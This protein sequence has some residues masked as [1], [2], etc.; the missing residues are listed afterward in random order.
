MP[1]R[2][3]RAGVWRISGDCRRPSPCDRHHRGS[4][5]HGRTRFCRK[6]NAQPVDAGWS[7]GPCRKTAG[8]LPAC[9]RR[10]ADRSSRGGS[11]LGRVSLDRPSPAGAGPIEGKTR[12]TLERTA[13]ETASDRKLAAKLRVV[14]SAKRDESGHSSSARKHLDDVCMSYLTDGASGGKSRR[15]STCRMPGLFAVDDASGWARVCSA[16]RAFDVPPGLLDTQGRR[17]LA[18]VLSLTGQ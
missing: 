1:Q 15:C 16:S 18:S 7:V 10:R 14:R 9:R 6:R 3:D 8:I 17:L 4:N 13:L 12:Q 5:S 11:A 2:S